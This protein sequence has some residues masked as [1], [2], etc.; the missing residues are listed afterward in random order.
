MCNK[1]V[2]LMNC[3]TEKIIVFIG[4]KELHCVQVTKEFSLYPFVKCTLYKCI[5]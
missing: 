1:K 2:Q 3:A 4:I 5:E